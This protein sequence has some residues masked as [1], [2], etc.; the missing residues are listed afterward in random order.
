MKFTT[1]KVEIAAELISV[2]LRIRLNYT[3]SCT[4]LYKYML[5]NQDLLKAI[6]SDSKYTFKRKRFQ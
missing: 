5:A 2:E 6:K 3:L 4:E 1:E